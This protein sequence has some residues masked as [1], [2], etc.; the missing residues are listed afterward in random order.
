MS[1]SLQ[2]LEVELDRDLFMR[3]LIRNLAGSL[4]SMVGLEEAVGFISVV[5]RAM[6]DQIDGAFK[7]A[8]EVDQFSLEETAAVL[9]ELKRRIDGDFRV[10]HI[11]E[12][13][14]VFGNSRCPFGD[15]VLDRPSMCMMT[16]NVFGTIA[17]ENHGYARVEIEKS[18]A[19]GDGEC[20][21][22]VHLAPGSGS[23]Q[24]RT[25]FKTSG[26]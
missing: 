4:E 20:L 23:G 5:G 22:T 15:K 2:N 12:T 19:A 13:K 14:I 9:V 7:E 10:V 6:G 8:M 17:A 25:Y 11:D 18:I 1:Q 26:L 24:G 16:S 3:T 21:V